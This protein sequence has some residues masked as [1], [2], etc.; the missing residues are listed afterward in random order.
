MARA[1]QTP[2]PA[3]SQVLVLGGFVIDQANDVR[4]QQAVG[5]EIPCKPPEAAVGEIPAWVTRFE[6]LVAEVLQ[7]LVRIP[8]GALMDGLPLC[9]PID[10]PVDLAGA[11]TPA[12]I[13][14]QT[15]DSGE[16]EIPRDL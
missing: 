3:R 13:D 1:S 10:D 7:G 5:V 4:V 14:F 12:V 9:T 16:A 11:T 15:R 2:G 8:H 6:A